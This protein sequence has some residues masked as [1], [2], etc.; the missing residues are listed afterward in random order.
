M[1]MTDLILKNSNDLHDAYSLAHV[2]IDWLAVLTRQI[3]KEVE[4]IQK[5]LAEQ[6]YED[7]NFYDLNKLIAIASFTADEQLEH[8]DSIKNRFKDSIE[9]LKTSYLNKEDKNK[10]A[11][12]L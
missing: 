3:K 5:E 9:Q 6:G 12:K 2:S 8:F 7:D 11:V 1:N 4:S 10:K